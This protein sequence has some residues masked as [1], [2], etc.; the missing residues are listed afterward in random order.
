VSGGAV[1]RPGQDAAGSSARRGA[2]RCGAAP[3]GAVRWVWAGSG[4]RR[5]RTR[6]PAVP[7]RPRAGAP[8]RSQET[9]RGTAPRPGVAAGGRRVRPVEG[10]PVR[11]PCGNRRTAGD[12]HR[13]A[14]C[15]GHRPGRAPRQ[16]GARALPRPS[17][18]A[19]G[20]V[21]VRGR[22]RAR[23]LD[24]DTGT[25]AEALQVCSPRGRS[26]V[27]ALR[28]DLVRLPCSARGPDPPEQNRP[29]R[30]HAGAWPAVSSGVG[31]WRRGALP[32]SSTPRFLV[33]GPL[34]SRPGARTARGERSSVWGHLPGCPPRA[35]VPGVVRAAS[36]RDRPP[37][38]RHS[39]G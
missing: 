36:V 26:P 28:P 6:Y 23:A 12:A 32:C 17:A 19:A 5:R 9:C 24:R 31:V 11:R 14:L 34:G 38:W 25:E 20:A 21:A 16:T 37:C 29:E 15:S 27:A 1:P 33:P 18:S 35:S 10:R 3:P 7:A 13:G 39:T 22:A 4:A 30:D 2:R 8:P